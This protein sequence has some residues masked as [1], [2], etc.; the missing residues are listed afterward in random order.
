MILLVVFLLASVDAAPSPDF[1]STHARQQIINY[2]K[3]FVEGSNMVKQTVDEISRNSQ[4]ITNFI[5]DTEETIKDMIEL[6]EEVDSD[7]VDT[8]SNV[9]IASKVVEDFMSVKHDLILTRQAL[10]SLAQATIRKT[11][12]LKFVLGAFETSPDH[13][14]LEI[15]IGLV[16]ELVSTTNE[17]LSLAIPIYNHANKMMDNIKFRLDSAL[18]TLDKAIENG[19]YW[20]YASDPWLILAD[21]FGCLG[22]INKK[23]LK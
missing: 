8:N 11:S 14:L 22:K 12:D 13:H 4:N 20:E 17:T 15:K 1:N 21:I 2:V 3:V 10:R 9:H 18:K 5:H 19:S 16:K 23:R 7:K 6:M